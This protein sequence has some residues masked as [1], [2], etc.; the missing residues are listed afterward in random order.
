MIAALEAYRAGLFQRRPLVRNIVAGLIAALFSTTPSSE[1]LFEKSE[2]MF[3]G[4][5]LV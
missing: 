5:T 3:A 2:L 4:G 1:A